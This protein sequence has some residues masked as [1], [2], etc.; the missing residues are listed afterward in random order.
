VSETT[1]AAQST[2]FADLLREYRLAARLTQEALAARAGLSADAVSALERGA[3]RTPRTSTIALLARALRLSAPDA[4]ALAAA[5]RWRSRPDPPPFEVPSDLRMPLT[6]LVGR[7]EE[8]ARARALLARPEVRLLTLTGPPGVGKT[9]LALAVANAVAGDF[10][11][12][13]FPVALAPLEDVQQVPAA[14]QQ[15]LRVREQ[16]NQLHL[17]TVIAYCRERHLLLV[18]DNVEHLLEARSLLLELLARCSEVRLLVTSRASLR[19]RTE[20]ELPV[21][22]L[23]LPDLDPESLAKTEVVGA[24]PSVALFVQRAVASA[25][26]FQLCAANAVAVATICHRLDGLPLALEL[27]APWIRLLTPEVMLQRLEQ[28]L[29][30]LVDGAHDLPER[31]RTM[32]AALTW[33]HDLLGTEQRALLRRLSVFAGSAPLQGIDAVCQAAAPLQGGV[34][35][36]LARLVEQSVVQRRQVRRPH[37]VRVGVLETVREYGRELLEAAGEALVTRRAHADYYVALT[38]KAAAELHGPGQE[39]WLGRL[40]VEYDNIRAALAWAAECGQWEVGLRLAAKLTDFWD[41][42]GGRREG[43]SWLERFVAAGDGTPADVWAEAL[44]GAA[45]MAWQVGAFE[46][47]AERYRTGLVIL[48]ELGDRPNVARATNG[49]GAVALFRGEYRR[50]AELFAE[51]ASLYRV[52]GDEGSMA[53]A[54]TNLAVAD[55][56]LGDLRQAKTL[57]D[58][59]LAI[60]RR[61]G[62]S[63]GAAHSAVCLAELVLIEGDLG[64]AEPLLAEALA[65]SRAASSPF[66]VAMAVFTLGDVARRRG[67]A[68]LARARYEE[69]MEVFGRTG[70]RVMVA[71]CLERLAWVA[72]AEEQPARAAR[73]YGAG[74]G[75]R[76]SLGALPLATDLAAGE[77]LRAALRER[78]GEDAFAVACAAGSHLS[79]EEAVAEAS[80]SFIASLTDPVGG[81]V[82]PSAGMRREAIVPRTLQGQPGWS[83]ASAAGPDRPDLEESGE[84]GLAR[85]GEAG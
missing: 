82:E 76:Q 14:I 61:L 38:A 47:S 17:E 33:S 41:L 26:D 16:R 43:L 23:R 52:V 20:H 11:D 12:G 40:E 78:L 83:H 75:L 77:P 35:R 81:V 42:R 39:L 53:T 8:V 18:L 9:R 3:R 73:L 45:R 27:A 31:Q 70:D 29:A 37:D 64:Q 34:L 51:A 22:P 56:Q 65:L 21:A 66:W 10:P 6:P 71:S 55:H 85:E 60:H 62:D 46:Q 2:S 74:V 80:G 69:S 4:E 24:A 72:W 58:D 68:A 30:L 67:D 5:A 1:G 63:V 79:L 13:V 25:P 36:C 49:L 32:R 19:I 54:L 50:A 84:G 48:R 44:I 28:R 15:A 7:D 59:A 57:Y